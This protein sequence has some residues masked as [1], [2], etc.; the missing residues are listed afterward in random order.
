MSYFQGVKKIKTKAKKKK[1]L[2]VIFEMPGNTNMLI[3][4]YMKEDKVF[5]GPEANKEFQ[6]QDLTYVLGTLKVPVFGFMRMQL[7]FRV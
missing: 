1:T 2:I 4:E 5:H 7:R 3:F 6:R